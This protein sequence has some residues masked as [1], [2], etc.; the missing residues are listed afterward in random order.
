MTTRTYSRELWVGVLNCTVFGVV[1]GMGVA[2]I[3]SALVLLVS[4]V[5]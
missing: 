3:V 4:P 5:L 2:I 1:I